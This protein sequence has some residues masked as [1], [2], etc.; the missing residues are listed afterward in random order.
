MV[1]GV[2]VGAVLFGR[3]IG[4]RHTYPLAEFNMTKQQAVGCGEFLE[5]HA[6]TFC[7]IF[8]RAICRERMKLITSSFGVCGA[9]LV[10]DG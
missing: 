7:A 9:G 10:M 8:A 6:A 1:P 2:L 3:V 4:R 5:L